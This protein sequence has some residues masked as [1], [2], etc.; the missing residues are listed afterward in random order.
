MGEATANLWFFIGIAFF[1]VI[2]AVI[3][4]PDSSNLKLDVGEDE[5]EGAAATGRGGAE[6]GKDEIT[7]AGA[8]GTPPAITTAARRSSRLAAQ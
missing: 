5:T 7:D 4:E 8:A 6:N 2:V 3:P 1:A